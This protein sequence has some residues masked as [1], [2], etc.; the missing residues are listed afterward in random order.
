MRARYAK[1][2]NAKRINELLAKGL[3]LYTAIP[4]KMG[5]PTTLIFVEERNKEKNEW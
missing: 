4:G 2:N 1:G 5:E 3:R